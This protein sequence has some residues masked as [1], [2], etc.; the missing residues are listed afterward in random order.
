[1]EEEIDLFGT[2]SRSDQDQG[3]QRGLNGDVSGGAG[4]AQLPPK[5]NIP[6]QKFTPPP[7]D[8]AYTYRVENNTNDDLEFWYDAP[9]SVRKNVTVFATS[10]REV[11]AIPNS[12][13]W[14]AGLDV[15]QL[16]RCD[17]ADGSRPSTPG[18]TT[19]PVDGVGAVPGTDGPKGTTTPT[20]E[21]NIKVVNNSISK[22]TTNYTIYEYIRGGIGS[23]K[24]R[25]K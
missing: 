7:A 17:N 22:G 11:C 20:K 10:N 25:I 1:M 5:P 23:N 21:I 15:Q 18:G 19:A 16:S 8:E 9:N 6:T 2:S 12:L 4:G 3:P 24:F 13:S 14:P